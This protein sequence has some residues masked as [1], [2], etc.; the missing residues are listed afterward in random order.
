MGGPCCDGHV[1]RVCYGLYGAGTHVEAES[2]MPHS[3]TVQ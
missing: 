3:T 1:A 2:T